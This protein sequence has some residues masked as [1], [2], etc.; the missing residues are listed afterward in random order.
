[1]IPSVPSPTSPT[2]IVAPDHMDPV[3]ESIHLGVIVRI[4]GKLYTMSK[5][6]EIITLYYGADV[7]LAPILLSL[8]SW[9]CN[10]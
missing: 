5:M 8:A 9:K 7:G 3:E 10:C 2:K 1:M 6:M 4:F